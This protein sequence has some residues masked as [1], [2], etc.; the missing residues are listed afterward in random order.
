[1]GINLIFVI[2]LPILLCNPRVYIWLFINFI[3]GEARECRG[4]LDT[5]HPQ[6]RQA[7]PRHRQLRHR[8]RPQAG[9][10]HRQ[11]LQPLDEGEQRNM[12]ASLCFCLYI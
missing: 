7:V 6:A 3:P 5:G 12:C 1:M 9:P 4:G 8:Y 2:Y 10:R 11:R